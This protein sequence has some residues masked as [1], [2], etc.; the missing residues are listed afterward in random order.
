MKHI[1]W[2][3]TGIRLELFIFNDQYPGGVLWKS[4]K[5]PG[6]VVPDHNIPKG[7]PGYATMQNCL[8][9]GYVYKKTENNEL[10]ENI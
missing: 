1:Q 2:K 5:T 6:V 4:C 3:D 8:K 10:D 9:L 7:S